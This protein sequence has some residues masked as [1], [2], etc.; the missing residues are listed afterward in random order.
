MH[1]YRL[2]GPVQLVEVK[3]L[4]LVR[5]VEGDLVLRGPG[6][7]RVIRVVRQGGHLGLGRVQLVIVGQDRLPDS[8]VETVALRG[9]L[10]HGDR[11]GEPGG[12]VLVLGPV[13][14][15]HLLVPGEGPVVEAVRG[16][17]HVPLSELGR[18]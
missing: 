5:V 1:R 12:P 17:V 16:L 7:H 15:G 6:P 11:F 18:W 9:R 14:G 10:R 13:A 3:V 2:A 8:Q 4:G